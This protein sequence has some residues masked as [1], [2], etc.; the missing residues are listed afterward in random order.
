[1]ELASVLHFGNIGDVWASLPAVKKM[2]EIKGKKIA[3][4]L[5]K[6]R[7]AIY[8]QGAVHPTKD[9]TGTMV[10]LNDKMIDMMVPLLEYQPY[11]EKATIWQG[12]KIDID[13]NKIRETNI[14]CPGGMLSRWYFYVYPN[15]A[16]DLSKPYIEIPE[17]DSILTKGKILVNRT[18]RYNNEFISYFFLKKYE[19]DIVFTGTKDEY[20]KFCKDWKLD[21]PYLE[22]KDFLELAQAIKQSK[23]YLSGQSQGF[24]IAEGLKHPRIVELCSFAQNVIPTGEHAYDFYAQVGLEYYVDYLF[25]L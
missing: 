11:I 21:I 25:N 16:S 17:T 3:Y 4:Y 6:D 7:R 20:N 23:F 10:M 1:M 19:S 24:Q 12:E 22:V 13:L 2:S 9:E 18:E 14:G 5:F 8:Y 15:L